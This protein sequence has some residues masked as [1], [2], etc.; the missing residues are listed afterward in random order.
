MFVTLN[1]SN[2]NSDCVETIVPNSFSVK[3]FAEVT[4]LSFFLNKGYCDIF[5][6]PASFEI[7]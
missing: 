3:I 1:L 6:I 5:F 4:I 7:K 2:F